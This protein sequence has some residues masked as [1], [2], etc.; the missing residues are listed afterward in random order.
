M[1][2]VSKI[3]AA[4]EA[5]G[6]EEYHQLRLWFSEKDWEKWDRQIESDSESGKLD[7]LFNEALNEKTK[8]KLKDL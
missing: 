6:E 7:F 3:K 4:I 1:S 2:K 5:L 8:G